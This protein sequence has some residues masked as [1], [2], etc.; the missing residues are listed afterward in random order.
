M[1]K[2]TV[3]TRESD[4]SLDTWFQYTGLTPNNF[5]C[6]SIAA[7]LSC[8]L[9]RDAL[10]FASRFLAI[11]SYA[12]NDARMMSARKRWIAPLRRGRALRRRKVM[13]REKRE[14]R[15]RRPLATVTTPPDARAS[16]DTGC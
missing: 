10:T 12:I 16:G 5:S 9:P 14:A 6:A 4:H 8:V 13:R 1:P 3:R 7:S 15:A 2:E 11:T